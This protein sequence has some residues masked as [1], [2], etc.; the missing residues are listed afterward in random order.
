MANQGWD[1]RVEFPQARSYQL[2]IADAKSQRDSDEAPIQEFER[3]ANIWPTAPAPESTDVTASSWQYDIDNIIVYHGSRLIMIAT[4]M[5]TTAAKD[6][7]CRTGDLS[8][9]FKT[10][11]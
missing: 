3:G 6:L 10:A 1:K 5:P 4:A 7:G 9:M 8:R 2:G 11:R